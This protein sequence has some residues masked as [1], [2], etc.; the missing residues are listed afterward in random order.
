MDHSVVF[1]RWCRCAPPAVWYVVPWAAP[2]SVHPKW[3][4][5]WFSRFC[6][7]HQCAQY[8]S[9]S[10]VTTLWHYTNLFIII[11]FLI[12]VLNSQWI[13]KIT[14]CNT[15]KVQKLCWNDSYSSSFF[16]KQSCI[17]PLNQNG[18][19]LLLLLY[20]YG[21]IQHITSVATGHIYAVHVMRPNNYY[22]TVLLRVICAEPRWLDMH[23]VIG[24]AVLLSTIVV[25]LVVHGDY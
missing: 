16:T 6:R 19:S 8:I 21:P 15:K 1:A 13:K 2:T 10:E 24:H 22:M 25:C 17:V 11:I 7:A 23:L 18:E 12:P 14:L 20:T 5:N 9:A 4:L 3:H